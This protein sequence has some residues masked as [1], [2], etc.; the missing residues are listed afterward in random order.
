MGSRSCS[1]IPSKV[2]NQKG[3]FGWLNLPTPPP[4]L[5][6]LAIYEYVSEWD[7]VKR[8]VKTTGQQGLRAKGTQTSG[9]QTLLT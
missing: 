1:T 9:E 6:P 2:L 7:F 4:P 3:E 8:L 5:P